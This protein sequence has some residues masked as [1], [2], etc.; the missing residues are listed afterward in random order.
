LSCQRALQS[1]KAAQPTHS[2]MPPDTS[3]ILL[4][5]VSV[6]QDCM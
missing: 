2:T 5:T 3:A 4:L 6:G 1:I